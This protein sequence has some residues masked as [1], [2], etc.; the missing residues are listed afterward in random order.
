[1]TARDCAGFSKLL[2]RLGCGTAAWKQ[3]PKSA[4]CNKKCNAR[5]ASGVNCR[6]DWRRSV[7]GPCSKYPCWPQWRKESKASKFAILVLRLLGFDIPDYVEKN[8]AKQQ[9][10]QLH[11]CQERL[12][13]SS[14][15]QHP[16]SIHYVWI[17]VTPEFLANFWWN[18]K[19][20]AFQEKCL[21][22][23]VT[24]VASKLRLLVKPPI[25]AMRIFSAA[26][27]SMTTWAPGWHEKGPKKMVRI[28]W[29]LLD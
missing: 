5:Y 7:D 6:T 20:W 11:L 15:Q 23:Q 18:S 2:R 16:L 9:L 13:F 29:Y 4:E 17:P 19:S 22:V 12:H 27:R 28:A 24:L 25:L 3:G 14:C 21:A 10:L 8:C 26:N 1:M